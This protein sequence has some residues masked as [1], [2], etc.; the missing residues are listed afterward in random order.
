MAQNNNIK[1]REKRLA[2]E[3]AEY[4]KLRGKEKAVSV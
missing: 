1:S 2:Y 3:G 4:P